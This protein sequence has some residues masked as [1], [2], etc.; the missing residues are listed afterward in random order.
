MNDLVTRDVNDRFVVPTGEETTPSGGAPGRGEGVRAV[1][2]H[3]KRRGV[4]RFDV[5][6]G[7]NEWV[8]RPMFRIGRGL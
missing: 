1:K 3:G 6:A 8:H 4:I 2:R 7:K 5:A